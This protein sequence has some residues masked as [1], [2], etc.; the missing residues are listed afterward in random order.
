MWELH[1]VAGVTSGCDIKYSKT[2]CVATPPP[3][4]PPPPPPGPPALRT[5]AQ[6]SKTTPGAVTY[7]LVV[8]PCTRTEALELQFPGATSLTAW[9]LS[10]GGEGP[11]APAADMIS[12]N[13]KNLTVRMSVLIVVFSCFVKYFKCA[14]TQMFAC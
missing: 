11:S 6:C 14:A 3:P 4:P 12:L 2:K 8:A 5:F 13:G 7:A 9:W 1:P 10:A